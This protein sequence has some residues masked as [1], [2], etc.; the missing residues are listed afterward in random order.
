MSFTNSSKVHLNFPP[1]LILA[2]FPPFRHH[3]MKWKVFQI[4]QG[5]ETCKIRRE[6]VPREGLKKNRRRGRILKDYH[7]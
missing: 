5:V 3:L 6:T 2:N 4:N 1:R 7:R